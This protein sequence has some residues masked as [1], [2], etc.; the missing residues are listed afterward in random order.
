[1]HEDLLQIYDKK[2][3]AVYWKN[4]SSVRGQFSYR[5]SKHSPKDPKELSHVFIDEQHAKTSDDKLFLR[6]L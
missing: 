3:L 2:E 6:L 1:M 5:R 4:W